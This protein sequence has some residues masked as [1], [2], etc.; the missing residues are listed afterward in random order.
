MDTTLRKTAEAVTTVDDF[1]RWT[2]EYLR[3]VL[4]HEALISGWGHMH[5]GGVGLDVMVMVDFPIEHVD[6]IRNRAGAIDTP[7]L[8]RWLAT[9]K[10]VIFDGDNPWPDT[11]AHWLE[12]FRRYDIRN[13]LAHAMWDSE[14]CGGTYHSFYRMPNAPGE[15]E[16]GILQDL[17]PVLHETFCRVIQSISAADR[18]SVCLDYLTAREREI[19]HWLGLGKTNAEIGIIRNLSESTVKHYV[20]EIFNKLGVSN[21]TQLARRLAEHQARRAP[22]YST[23]LL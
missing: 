4:P 11:P 20:T 16:A 1:K 10:P 9:E 17:L 3:A 7:I 5:A 22:G 14:R 18:F 8:R 19:V 15:R 23:K 13:V 12:R 2:R 6:A 21:R